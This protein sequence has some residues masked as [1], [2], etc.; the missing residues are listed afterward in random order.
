MAV[1][2]NK[3]P[4]LF[5]PC[6]FERAAQAVFPLKLIGHRVSSSWLRA[7]ESVTEFLY[8]TAKKRAQRQE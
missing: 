1:K 3:H 7:W 4:F 8:D 5:I 2:I 6:C